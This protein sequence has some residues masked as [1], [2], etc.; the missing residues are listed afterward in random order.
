MPK[1]KFGMVSYGFK[2]TQS[3]F[4]TNTSLVPMHFNLKVASDSQITFQDET[5]SKSSEIFVRSSESFR[6]PNDTGRK[7]TDLLPKYAGSY[8][9]KEFSI[10]PSTGILPPQSEIKIY[11][12]FVPHYLKK[13]ETSLT[14]DIDNVGTDLY[15]LP[16]T[17]R[18]SVP[19]INLLTTGIDMGRCF[20]NYSYEKHVK[21]SNESSLKARYIL[22]T[23]KPESPFR[24]SS[25]QLEVS[26]Q[27][28]KWSSGQRVDQ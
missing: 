13:Y 8:N 26:D 1:L 6:S 19:T 23:D 10:T 22:L 12:D 15:N 20:I 24:F 2:Y 9:F 14:V 18:S 25:K 3:C 5:I 17:A 28:V 7:S 11:I 4:L 27:L 16:I 21:L